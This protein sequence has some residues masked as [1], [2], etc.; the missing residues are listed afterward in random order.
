MQ[1]KKNEKCCYNADH[2][3]GR[4]IRYMFEC[5]NDRHHL[6]LS[7]VIKY[8]R[9]SSCIIALHIYIYIYIDALV[10]SIMVAARVFGGNFSYRCHQNKYEA[11]KQGIL[12]RV[13][14]GQVLG[15]S[16]YPD[17]FP[18]YY[19]YPWPGSNHVFS[20]WTWIVRVAGQNTVLF[21]GKTKY[22]RHGKGRTTTLH[23]H[24]N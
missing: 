18:R 6:L 22:K 20:T 13:V 8:Y 5:M 19:P 9:L 3:D 17:F 11:A 2:D 14:S 16:G 23:R 1:P 7:G 4:E 12:S 24:D 10:P 15:P 21:T